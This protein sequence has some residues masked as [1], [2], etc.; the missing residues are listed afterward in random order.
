MFSQ[1]TVLTGGPN[2]GKTTLLRAIAQATGATVVDEKATE[3][4]VEGRHSPLSD[5]IAFRREVLSRQIAAEYSLSCQNRPALLDRGRFDGTAYCLA[6][7]CPVPRFLQELETERPYRIA[8]V[9]DPVP[10]WENDGI[11][12]EDPD[13]TL[14]VNPIF[15]RLYAEAG[16][17]VF[18]V[19]FMKVED[20][21]RMVLATIE[22]ENNHASAP[23]RY[24]K[25][26]GVWQWQRTA[27]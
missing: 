2:V 4:I 25:R 8:F 16:A 1:Q 9:L 3:V 13:F 20:R 19:P 5:P 18:R 11:R 23:F 21:L 15:A 12:Y 17:R 14:K 6:T 22:D 27:A 26:E 10:T 24:E 7:G